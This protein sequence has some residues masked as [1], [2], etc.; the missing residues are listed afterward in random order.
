MS[1][2]ILQKKAE[3]DEAE[4]LVSRVM[5]M[6]R[7][8]I[9]ENELR[10]DDRLPS[11]SALAEHFGV[12]RTVTREAFRALG[13]LSVLKIGNGRRARVGAPDPEP[14]SI[15][16]D[17]TVYTRELSVQQV[18]DIRRTLELRTASLA[19]LRRTDARARELLDLA[20]AM[21]AAIDDP[22]TLM[23]YDIR[24]HEL[25]ARASG[26][27]LYAVLVGSFK[28]ITRQ[29]WPIGWRSR[30]ALENRMQNLELHRTIAKAIA[31]QDPVRA[32]AAMSEHFDSAVVAL[33]HA[34]V[35]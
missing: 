3:G 28:V 26:N 10:A 31:A 22:E 16:I 17:H 9:R 6:T 34:G 14:L 25:I 19:A 7:D 21:I 35:T 2:P 12:S 15:I 20:A 11:E 8:Y 23:E 27:S 1:K 18:L 32:E 30:T 33:I 24:F 29:T 4:G 5:Q 13:A